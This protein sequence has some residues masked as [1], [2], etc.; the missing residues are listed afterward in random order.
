MED[1]KFFRGFCVHAQQLRQFFVYIYIS[2]LIILYIVYLI[3]ILVLENQYLH[4]SHTCV[5]VNTI[6]LPS[7]VKKVRYACILILYG[8]KSRL[9]VVD[10]VVFLGQKNPFFLFG[11]NSAY[12]SYKWKSFPY[13]L[14][15]LLKCCEHYYLLED[16]IRCL[17][18]ALPIEQTGT[19]T[20]MKI[21]EVDYQIQM[22]F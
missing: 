11:Q 15:C 13:N 20:T 16:S 12:R 6:I 7:R 17:V 10:E 1:A 9:V 14:N 2:K 22:D 19:K 8:G 3:L 21:S 18:D 4:Y 5:R